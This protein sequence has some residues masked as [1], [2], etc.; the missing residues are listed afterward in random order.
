MSCLIKRRLRL[1]LRSCVC[2]CFQHNEPLPK[3]TS[4]M[5]SVGSLGSA[6]SSSS[7]QHGGEPEL[8]VGLAYSESTGRLSVEVIKGSSFKNLASS[9]APGVI[10]TWPPAGRVQSIVI[11]VFV[12]LFVCLSVRSHISKTTRPN[13]SKFSN[14]YTCYLWP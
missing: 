13:F 6:D 3:L 4:K 5:A 2:V 11:S 14:L 9:K 8:M 10:I 12:C 1:R 7:M